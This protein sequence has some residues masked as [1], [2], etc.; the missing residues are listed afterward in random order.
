[1]PIG[2][3]LYTFTIITKDADD[4]M[5]HLHDRMPVILPRKLGDAWL[6]KEIIS[7]REVLDILE[8]GRGA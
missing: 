4:F 6:N 8:R 7:A 3:A 1:M 2:E 5:A